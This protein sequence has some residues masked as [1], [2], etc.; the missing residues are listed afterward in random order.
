MATQFLRNTRATLEVTFSAGNADADVDVTV[1]G[2]N[3]TTVTSGV[4]SATGGG[5]YTFPVNP[6]SQ[7]NRLDVEWAGEWGG[8]AQSIVT[9]AEVVSAHLFTL[10][11]ARAYR[12]QQ[13]ADDVT[14]P[15][16]DIRHAR[17]RITD[18]FQVVCGVAFFPRYE[19]EV[20]DGR[21]GRR[22]WLPHKRPL[23]LISA[24]VD[25][26]TLSSPELSEVILF[27]TGR[28]ERTAG[29]TSGY[30]NVVIEYERGYRRIPEEVRRAALA[31]V[32]YE[33]VSSEITDRMVSFANELGTVRLSTPGRYTPTGIPLVDSVLWRYD[34]RDRELVAIR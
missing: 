17:D 10:A 21:G 6:L 8:V 1:R 22:I 23:S 30:Q 13:L 28:I 7:L 14:Y 32:H 19:R 25:G 26:V 9:E 15:D 20:V 31:L 3:G 16:D 5:H 18:A 2:E 33:L 29:W 34:E 11:E 4:A 12:D 27:R 24:T